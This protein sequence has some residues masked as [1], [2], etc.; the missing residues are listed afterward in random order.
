MHHSI[1]QKFYIQ[2]KIDA[3]EKLLD[4]ILRWINGKDRMKNSF[5]TV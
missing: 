5:D 1:N 4:E 3:I 2:R